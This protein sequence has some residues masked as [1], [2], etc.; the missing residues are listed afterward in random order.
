MTSTT[1]HGQSG[2]TLIETTAT[3]ALIGMAVMVA[4]SLL[5]AHPRAAERLEAQEE[6]LL[7]L[8]ATIESLRS[9]ALELDSS[10]ISP[11]I[12][13]DRPVVVEIEVTE[14]STPGLYEI[15]VTAR[16]EVRDRAVTRS[17]HSMIWRPS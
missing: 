10:R 12:P 1:W 2:I 16:S 7:V 4:S 11:P 13:V 14:H 3:I 15:T 17:Q 8:E 5:S 6:L 9:G